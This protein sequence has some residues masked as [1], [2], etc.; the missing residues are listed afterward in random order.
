[1]FWHICTALLASP[2]KL[3]IMRTGSKVLEIVSLWWHI[4]ELPIKCDLLSITSSFEIS[5]WAKQ[6]LQF[7]NDTLTWIKRFFFL[8]VECSICLIWRSIHRLVTNLQ[9]MC[10]RFTLPTLYI[11]PKPELKLERTSRDLCSIIISGETA[12]TGSRE[13]AINYITDSTSS[14]RIQMIPQTSEYLDK[15]VGPHHLQQ[16]VRCSRGRVSLSENLPI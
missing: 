8:P 10:C 9:K 14:Q 3:K 5:L 4:E 15:R 1:M 16:T 11:F 13:I 6:I 12:Q 7:S 2:V